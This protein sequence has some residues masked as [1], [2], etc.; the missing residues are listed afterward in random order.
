[1]AIGLMADSL[2]PLLPRGRVREG[3]DPMP[4]SRRDV[5]KGDEEARL[6]LAADLLLQFAMD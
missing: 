2:L 1:M 3:V 4:D 5:R 6:A